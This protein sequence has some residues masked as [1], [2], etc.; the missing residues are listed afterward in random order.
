MHTRISSRAVVHIAWAA[1]VYLDGGHDHIANNDHGIERA[2][3]GVR[4]YGE[5]ASQVGRCILKELV[6]QV[7]ARFLGR[8]KFGGSWVG[9][10]VTPA[11]R[12]QGMH[13]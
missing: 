4:R 3:D 5:C 6:D 7:R 10:W 2:F 1:S 8:V 11:A 12:R 9:A 13:A